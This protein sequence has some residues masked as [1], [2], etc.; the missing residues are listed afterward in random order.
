MSV[1]IENFRRELSEKLDETY[2]QALRDAMRLFEERNLSYASK[3]ICENLL[4]PVVKQKGA[5]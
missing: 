5:V 2:C 4:N 1:A 3:L